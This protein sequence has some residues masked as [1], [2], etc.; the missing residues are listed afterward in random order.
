MEPVRQA[1]E[2]I[3]RTTFSGSEMDE[4]YM[5][6]NRDAH[7]TCAAMARSVIAMIDVAQAETQRGDYD[8]GYADG[9]EW[10]TKQVEQRTPKT[11]GGMIA[12]VYGDMDAEDCSFID[13]EWARQ[14]GY[15]LPDNATGQLAHAY[16]DVMRGALLSAR[17]A[18][19]NPASPASRDRAFEAINK[20][21]SIPSTQSAAAAEDIARRRFG[22]DHDRPC[23]I[24]SV[25]T[26]A[27]SEC[28][29]ANKCM[30]A[31]SSTPRVG[32]V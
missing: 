3:A 9:I 23:K 2:A 11:L 21:L 6:G 14:R 24:D 32:E 22:R 13:F 16:A 28:Q 17:A 25:L 29:E 27:F 1:L 15:I 18:L 8:H 19:D 7:A 5:R 26:C 31:V 20:A 10:A 4:S 30:A 12:A